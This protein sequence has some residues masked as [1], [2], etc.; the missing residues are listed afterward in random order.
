MVNAYSTYYNYDDSFHFYIYELANFSFLAFCILLAYQ[1]KLLAPLSMWVW[2]AL[3]FVPLLG[4]YFLFS[5]YLFGDQFAYFDE[6]TALKT[7]GESVDYIAATKELRGGTVSEITIT[8]KILGLVPIPATMT[9]TSL[10][11]ANKFLSFFLFL[12]LSRFFDEKKL[13][14][15]FLIPS[16][17]LF[18]SVGLRDFLILFLSIL[19]LLYLVRR[20]YFFGVLFL[21]PLYFLKIQMFAFISIYLLGRAIFQAHKS[22][23]GMLLFA[24]LGLTFL[25]I[26]QD[27]FLL[28]INYY[29]V[30]FYAE[31]FA[32]GYQG[33]GK[34][35]DASLIEV[36][37]IFEF[38]WQGLINLPYL[39]FMPLPWQWSSPLSALQSVES[40]GL[41]F[42]LAYMIKKYSRAYDQ[43]LIFL[44][45]CMGLGMFVYSFLAENV[46]TFVRYRFTL[47]LPFFIACI[48]VLER[49]YSSAS[50]ERR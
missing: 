34:Y 15:I 7:T 25:I 1:L 36:N 9:V 33:F 40:F 38:M 41:I 31:N 12:W 47:F 35:G 14:L 44:L 42:A 26:F 28:W 22:F 3:S 48:Y 24:I 11:F 27:I 16:F 23:F 43:E 45:A 37:S 13:L 50:I 30:G 29:K 32:G 46:G 10:S 21:A 4:N 2:L 18:A 49:N 19:S 5:P 20:N 8:A 6:I 17:V 39:A